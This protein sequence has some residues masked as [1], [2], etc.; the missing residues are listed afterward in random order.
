MAPMVPSDSVLEV[1]IL[2]TDTDTQILDK[3]NYDLVNFGTSTVN[4]TKIGTTSVIQHDSLKSFPILD[5][6]DSG[7]IVGTIQGSVS[8][9]GKVLQ[10]YDSF[11]ETT[12]YFDFVVEGE[13]DYSGTFP[14][15]YTP[16]NI[17]QSMSDQDILN[18][19]GTYLGFESIQFEVSSS[20]IK[21]TSSVAIDQ[22]MVQVSDGMILS[23]YKSG[24]QDIQ[25]CTL[26][27]FYN[28]NGDIIKVKRANQ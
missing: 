19:I 22:A 18:Y 28:V 2:S 17:L 9:N 8:L 5:S 20:N 12:Q 23:V 21:F 4:T 14:A 1:G 13:T 6:G 15:E 3:F 27:L 16:L 26:E 11:S 24:V 25:I 7:L 10:I